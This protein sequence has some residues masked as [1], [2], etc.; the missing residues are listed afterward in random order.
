MLK[1]NLNIFSVVDLLTEPPC[2]SVEVVTF[3]IQ[4]KGV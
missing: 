4:M 2:I 3:G 1:I